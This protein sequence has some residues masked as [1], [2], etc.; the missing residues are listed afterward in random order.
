MVLMRRS[1]IRNYVPK[2]QSGHL[3]YVRLKTDVGIFYKI[4][5]TTASSVKARFDYAGSRDSKY[6][7]EVLLFTHSNKAYEVEQSLHSCLYD[8]KA[9]EEYSANEHFPL[10]R[11]GQTEL[12]I[13]DVLGLDSEYSPAQKKQTLKLMEAKNIF[14]SNKSEAQYK[15]E[16]ICIK[17]IAGIV[18]IALFPIVFLMVLLY[19][20]I[21]RKSS[22]GYLM[23]LIDRVFRGG[24]G[25]KKKRDEEIKKNVGL[26]LKSL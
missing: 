18:L 2:S 3:Y 24:R 19:N 17:L 4:G 20:L 10:S 5:F 1:S 16:N 21:T 13:E 14:I 9:F 26:I 15:F 8:K 12:Y 23:A 25:A 11:N 6:I 7:D 22:K